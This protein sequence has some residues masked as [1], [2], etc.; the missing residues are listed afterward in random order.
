MT[1]LREIE[2]ILLFVFHSSKS[3]SKSHFTS[4]S[5][6]SGILFLEAKGKTSLLSHNALFHFIFFQFFVYWFDL[7][8]ICIVINSY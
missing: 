2:L 8:L 1:R 5:G 3:K 4:K 7:S 6:I